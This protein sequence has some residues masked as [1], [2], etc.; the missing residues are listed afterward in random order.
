MQ[1]QPQV[2]FQSDCDPLA[3]AAQL[4]HPLSFGDMQR[5]FDGTKEKRTV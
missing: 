3:Q 5:R 4:A 2:T 1:H